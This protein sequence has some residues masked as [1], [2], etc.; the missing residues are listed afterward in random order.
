MSRVRSRVEALERASERLNTH[1]LLARLPTDPAERKELLE[2]IRKEREARLKGG[3][4]VKRVQERIAA[5]IE[6]RGM[7]IEPPTLHPVVKERTELLQRIRE[8]RARRQERK[9][10]LVKKVG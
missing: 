2:R 4:L 1:P 5:E 8:E 10:E 3:D 6:A 7:V 9:L